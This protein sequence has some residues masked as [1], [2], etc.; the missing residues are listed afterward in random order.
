MS[1]SIPAF[2]SEL[3]NVLK[4]IIT[5]KKR[6]VVKTELSAFVFHQQQMEPVKTESLRTFSLR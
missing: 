3:I 2:S 4:Q 1:I 5:T 6:D